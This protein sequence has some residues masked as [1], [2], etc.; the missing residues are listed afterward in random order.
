MA[1][2]TI[3][4]A[5][6]W[7]TWQNQLRVSDRWML[8]AAG[9]GTVHRPYNLLQQLWLCLAAALLVVV[10]WDEFL[11][12]GMESGGPVPQYYE[13]SIGDESKM[14]GPYTDGGEPSLQESIRFLIANCM[15]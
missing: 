8:P 1:R 11:A 10:T 7:A 14:L 12:H 3:R 15:V 6:C 4:Q 9:G 2:M 5:A 13:Q